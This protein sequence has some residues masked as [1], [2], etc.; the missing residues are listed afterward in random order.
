MTD[1]RGR[2]GSTR[3]IRPA[4]DDR[5]PFRMERADPNRTIG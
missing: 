1:E 3:T 2:S 5:N 4:D